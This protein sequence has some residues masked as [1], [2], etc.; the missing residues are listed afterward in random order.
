[1]GLYADHILPRV[2]DRVMNKPAIGELRARTAA[3]L[4]GEVLEVGFGS[5][6]SLAFYP[7]TV[8]RVHAVD[9]ALL[10]RKLAAERIAACAIP[11]SFAGED[12][13]LVDLPD[14]S[15]D[16]ALCTW[17]LCTIPDA[18]RALAEVR[19]VLKPGGI[20]RFVEHGRHER[21][22]LAKWQDRLNP[23]QRLLAGGCNLNRPMDALIRD[24][25]FFVSDL[26]TFSMERSKNPFIW[27]YL[28]TATK[29]A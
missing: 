5:G 12:A 13:Q 26:E 3:P 4:H 29:P 21:P 23:L 19:R 17:T 14:A 11:V 22:N 16:S 18:R 15:V 8:Q 7:D 9:P 24:A 25:G 2:V 10:G 28:G 20:L 1:M 6:L 27:M